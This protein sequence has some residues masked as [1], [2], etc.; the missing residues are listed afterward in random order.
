MKHSDVAMIILI[1]SI[2]LLVSYFVGNAIFGGEESRSTQVETVETISAEFPQPSEKI[3]N[4]DAI[5]LTETI[6]IGDTKA[7]SPFT[8]DNQ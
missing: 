4:K 1:T 3:F 8:T 6:N 7:K 2:S 5:N